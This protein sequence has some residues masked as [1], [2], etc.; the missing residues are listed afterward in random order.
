MAERK[1]ILRSSSS[2]ILLRPKLTDGRLRD[3]NRDVEFYLHTMKGETA[4]NQLKVSFFLFSTVLIN[5]QW[6]PCTGAQLKAI[7]QMSSIKNDPITIEDVNI[8]EKIF[9]PNVGSLK[10][11][12]T[13]QKPLPVVDDFIEIPKGLVDKQQNVTLCID[14]LKI[15]GIPFLS[16]V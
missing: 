11:K 5:G 6:T 14:V 16:T 8:A 4:L 15:N 1:P 13:R 3:K 2:L 10:G 7:L 9:G 12:T